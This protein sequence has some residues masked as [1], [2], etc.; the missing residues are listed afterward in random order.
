M[1]RLGIALVFLSAAL[2]ACASDT[3][4]VP[5]PRLEQP[6]AFVAVDGDGE[7]ALTLFRTLSQLAV[8][9][10]DTILFIT[11]YDVDPTT[12]DEA[13]D[14]SK[15]HDIPIRNE[16]TSASRSLLIQSDYRVVWFRTLTEEEEERVE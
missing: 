1:V 6:G 4:P 16:I 13:R 12:W 9:G 3:V 8:Q 5:E 2:P 14:I 7:G 15:G 11:V 10:G